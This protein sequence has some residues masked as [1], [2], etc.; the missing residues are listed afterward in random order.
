LSGAAS[1]AP[2]TQRYV[3]LRKRM[4]KA[5]HD[6]GVGILLGS[7]S[8]QIFNVPGFSIHREL[9]AMVSAGLSPY[10]ALQTG[11]VNPEKFFGRDNEVG[12]LAAGLVADLVLV[13]GNPLQDISNAA[14]V[15][16][17]MVRGRWLDSNERSRKLA[18]IA[19]RYAN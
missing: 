17:V 12:R 18:E 11:T 15:K 1:S 3:E 14:N 13:A 2:A 9:R 6:H 16:G 5:M 19:K 8:P 4:L 10:E 7:D